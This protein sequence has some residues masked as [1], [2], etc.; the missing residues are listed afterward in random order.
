MAIVLIAPKVSTPAAACDTAG[1]GLTLKVN[2]YFGVSPEVLTD[3]RRVAAR[4]FRSR[5]KVDEVER[6]LVNTYLAVKDSD[7]A[8][9]FCP[10]GWGWSSIVRSPGWVSI[11]N[12]IQES[13]RG[14]G[15]S[16][17]FINYER[18]EHSFSGVVGE[19]I[20]LL[21]ISPFKGRELA[22]RIDFL[23]RHLPDLRV[24]LTGES[25]GAAMVEDTMRFLRLNPRVYCIQT[26]PPVWRPSEPFER[27]LIIAHNGIE[28][29]TFTNGDIPRMVRANI[30]AAF[31][32]Y[33]GTQGNILF[34]IGA[35]GHAYGWEFDHVRE[36]ITAFIAR[37]FAPLG[38]IV[39]R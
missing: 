26:G 14:Y 33:E 21:G 30:L 32:K 27:S 7:V 6:Q 18:T 15:Q 1:N 11:Q 5:V 4:R 23:T 28:P 34:Y 29:D 12:G 36:E 10:G 31:G 22:R 20:V 35:P 25:N 8:I 9:I 37:H 39:L 2:E 24:L 19:V 38:N 16:A 13:L 17:A 3:A